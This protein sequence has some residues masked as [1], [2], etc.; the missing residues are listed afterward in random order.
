[1]KSFLW[2]MK[3]NVA[4]FLAAMALFAVIYIP[5]AYSEFYYSD[6][7]YFVQCLQ[8]TDPIIVAFCVCFAFFF[9]C[10]KRYTYDE[11]YLYGQSRKGAFGSAFCSSAIYAVLFACYALGV[12]LL[13]RRAI[14]SAPNFAVSSD[15]YRISADEIFYNFALLAVIDLVAYE[16]A[17]MLRKFRSWRFWLTLAVCV[18]TLVFLVIFNVIL[19]QQNSGG[20]Y[21]AVKY[22]SAMFSV[23]IPQAA[24]M[25]AGD[26]IMTRGRL[27]R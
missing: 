9:I 8:H 12:A 6:T 5:L 1:M 27:C 11:A 24:I 23:L 16:A 25:I 20:V 10:S 4:Y 14:L 2:R 21:G 13:V 15:I 7:L 19:P 26:F 22:W 3:S 18:T 17:N